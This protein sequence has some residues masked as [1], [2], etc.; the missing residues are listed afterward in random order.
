M[1]HITLL[2]RCHALLR[3]VDT[4]TPEGRLTLDGD[5]L[6]KEITDYINQIGSHHQ[7]CW[8]QGP[9][10]YVCAYERVKE[11]EQQIKDQ[12]NVRPAEVHMGQGS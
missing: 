4:V 10:H 3:R 6:A 8:A 11:L 7:D 9:E 5:R 2:M 12:E 1:K